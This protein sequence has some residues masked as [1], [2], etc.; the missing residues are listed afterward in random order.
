MMTLLSLKRETIQNIT[1]YEI[2]F[3]L[4]DK[5]ENQIIIRMR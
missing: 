1:V 2:H 3:V 5:E 4:S